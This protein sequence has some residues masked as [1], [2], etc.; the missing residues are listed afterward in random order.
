MLVGAVVVLRRSPPPP[1]HAFHST[2]W[3]TRQH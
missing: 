2:T 3:Y 1:S